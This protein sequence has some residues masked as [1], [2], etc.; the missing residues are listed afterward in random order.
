MKV[1][2]C[3]LKLTISQRVYC[4]VLK[5]YQTIKQKEADFHQI[6]NDKPLEGKCADCTLC[7][8]YNCLPV[9]HVNLNDDFLHFTPPWHSNCGLV[10]PASSRPWHG[11]GHKQQV[12][13]GVG[14]GSEFEQFSTTTR[15]W[16]GFFVFR[17]TFNH[18]THHHA[19]KCE[20]HCLWDGLEERWAIAG[21]LSDFESHIKR[22]LYCTQV[23]HSA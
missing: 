9:F 13:Q 8:A 3:L 20:L 18:C 2:F 12:L 5:C 10:A 4:K 15:D 22:N 11:L 1:D 17:C 14:K 16:Q 23:T 6:I 19:E 7:L 21:S